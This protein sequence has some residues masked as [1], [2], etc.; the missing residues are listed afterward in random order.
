MPRYEQVQAALRNAPRTWPVTGVASFIG[1][2]L[3]EML[4]L[5]QR[6]VGLDNFATG[7]QRNVDEV[8]QLVSPEQWGRFRFID[9]NI[10]KFGDCPNACQGV[11]YVF[12]QVALGSLLRSL[13][14]LITGKTINVGGFLNIQVAVRDAEVK[15]IV[16]AASSS[17]YGDHPG[18]PKIEYVI[19]KLF[20]LY[21]ITNYVN[22]LH[23]DVF[24][25]SFSFTIIRLR[26]FNVFGKRQDSNGANAFVIHNGLQR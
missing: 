9:G 14:D 6:V 21:A 17:T 24:A 22:E 19:G 26:Y 4:R 16:Y 23:P 2:K 13:N 11:D 3:L 7:H 8:Q 15:S 5:D 18:L 10:R 12:H 20:A 25:R 1:S